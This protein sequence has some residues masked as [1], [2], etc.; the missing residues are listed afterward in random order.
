MAIVFGGPGVSANLRGLPSNVQTLQAGNTE[1]IPAGTWGIQPSGLRYINVEQYDPITTTWRVAGGLT[2]YTY[3]FSDG[4]NYRIANRTGCVVGAYLTNAGTGY[5]SAPTVTVPSSSGAKLLPV[6]SNTAHLVNTSP[7]ITAG[8]SNYVYPPIVAFAAP[9]AGGIQATGYATLSSGAVS[10]ITVTNQGGGYVSAPAIFLVNDPRDTAGGGATATCTLT[11][12]QTLAGILVT[13]FGNPVSAVPAITI[14]G[15]GGSGAAATAVLE[16]V[17]TSY[18]VTSAGSG[19]S[20]NVL[21]LGFSAPLTSSGT[22]PTIQNN[23]VNWRQVSIGAA[24]SGVGLT[25]TGQTVYDGGLSANV[26]TG[27]VM[28]FATGSAA[29]VTFTG[30]GVTDTVVMLAV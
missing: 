4:N 11:G 5:T 6:W 18:T 25:A 15:G 14:S 9:P 16:Y 1:L 10:S 28:G 27:Y 3:V 29:Q 19:Y 26:P 7:T 2:G 21:V 8:G 24:L 12:A 13:D 22:N 20:G 17:V 30:S 23:L